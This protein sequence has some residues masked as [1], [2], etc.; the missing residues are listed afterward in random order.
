[1]E[2]ASHSNWMGGG[3]GGGVVF[4]IGGLHISV[5]VPHGRGISF[6]WEFLKKIVGWDWVP[7]WPLTRY[8]KP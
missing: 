5:V 8:G 6:D 7:S 1:M 3:G 2:G 4:Q